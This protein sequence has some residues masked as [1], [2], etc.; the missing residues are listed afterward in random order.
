MTRSLRLFGLVLAALACAAVARADVAR[1]EPRYVPQAG[2]RLVYRAVRYRPAEPDKPHVTDG[3]DVTVYTVASSDG[4]TASGTIIETEALFPAFLCNTTEC[5]AAWEALSGAPPG[6][7]ALLPMAVPADVQAETAPLGEFRLRLFL[8]ELLRL[9]LL[10][11]R[12]T[13]TAG[14]P[15]CCDI[16]YAAEN[17]LECDPDAL[18]TFV[19]FGSLAH[20]SLACRR[21]VRFTHIKP[22]RVTPQD[23]ESD[24]KLELLDN[25]T[26][27]ITTPAGP[28]VVRNLHHTQ[29][30][31][32]LAF[33]DEIGAT[34]R[35]H[36]VVKRRADNGEWR[37]VLDSESELI[38]VR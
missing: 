12:E 34:V 26:S 9:P 2:L 21:S 31:T 19:P 6:S 8:P 38:F 20:L 16:R 30:V 23:A 33:S 3:V 15:P 35:S 28:F 29:R 5:K 11:P 18:H 1:A 10:W 27:T 24:T 37:T 17:K 7:D 13:P 4:T 32:D 22:A 36:T 14:Q 25:G